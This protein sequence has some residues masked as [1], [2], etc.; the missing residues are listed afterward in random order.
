MNRLSEYKRKYYV[1]EIKVIPSRGQVIVTICD[2]YT[3]QFFSGTAVCLPEDKFDATLGVAI[4]EKRAVLK[5]IQ[6]CT[7]DDI[8]NLMLAVDPAPER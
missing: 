4:A 3:E 8:D 6:Y 2:D 5:M 7:Q 1:D